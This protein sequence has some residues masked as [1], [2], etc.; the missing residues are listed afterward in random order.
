MKSHQ[1]V[2]VIGILLACSVP[3]IGTLYAFGWMSYSRPTMTKEQVYLPAHGG[4]LHELAPV[5]GLCRRS[6]EVRMGRETS[7]A[8]IWQRRHPIGVSISTEMINLPCRL[9]NRRSWP[10]IDYRQVGESDVY[11]IDSGEITWELIRRSPTQWSL[12]QRLNAGGTHRVYIIDTD[13]RL[14]R[15]SK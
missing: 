7:E 12:R 13:D 4:D 3:I 10:V 6:G 8:Q 2:I 15:R 1:Y 9:Q 14:A 11:E 5:R